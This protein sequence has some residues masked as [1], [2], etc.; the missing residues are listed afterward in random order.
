MACPVIFADFTFDSILPTSNVAL[1]IV[2]GIVAGLGLV[3]M[4][5]FLTRPR[6]VTAGVSVNVTSQVA[7]PQAPTAPSDDPFVSGSG[8]EQRQ[9]FRRK[10]NPVEVVVINQKNQGSP[11]KGY[12]V[13]RSVGGLCLQLDSPIEEETQLSV[14][15]ANAPHIAPW[16]DVVVKNCR[17]GDRD[18]E[19]GC[20]FV[21]VP[22]WP[23]LMMF[24]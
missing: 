24:G 11:L 3:G 10:G 5:H 20:Q 17:R 1:P 9:S 4:I 16:V 21:K 14:R 23:V 22:P 12:V 2:V 7:A 8:S 6:K 18:F 19:I 15:P 13:N